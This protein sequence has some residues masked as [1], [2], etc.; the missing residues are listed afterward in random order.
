MLMIKSEYRSFIIFSKINKSL[1]SLVNTT[2]QK[3]DELT[4]VYPSNNTINEEI[5]MTLNSKFKV[6]IHKLPYV[7]EKMKH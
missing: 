3:T 7:S 4:I 5:V 6:S 2:F 1:L